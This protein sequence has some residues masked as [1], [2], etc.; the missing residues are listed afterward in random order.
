MKVTSVALMSLLVCAC[1][2]ENQ[3]ESD[4]V[5]AVVSGD[6]AKVEKILSLGV[7][8]NKISEEGIV[9]IMVATGATN[10]VSDVYSSKT[11]YRAVENTVILR[12]LLRSGANANFENRH[13]ITPLFTAVYHGRHESVSLLLEFG[14][15]PNGLS[16]VGFTPLMSASEHCMPLV[17]RTL[18]S[19]GADTKTKSRSGETALEIATRVA[20]ADLDAYGSYQD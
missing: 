9:P 20:C 10:I 14:A 19:G 3:G 6:E 11:S 7:D 13:G 5:W 4:L 1:N 8:P 18:V 17:A 16:D 15:D 2:A 12:L